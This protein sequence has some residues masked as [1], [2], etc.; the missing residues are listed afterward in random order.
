VCNLKD[1][2]IN[3]TFELA[4]IHGFRKFTIDDIAKHLGISKK[5]IY[6]NFETKEEI[7]DGVLSRVLNKVKEKTLSAIDC[8]T[9]WHGKM[10]A[11]ILCH[12]ID[13]IPIETL[14][15]IKNIF[16][17]KGHKIEDFKLF[18]QSL[19]SSMLEEGKCKN[20]IRSNV[21]IEVVLIILERTIP[22]ITNYEFLSN[23]NYRLNESIDSLI[24]IIFDGINAP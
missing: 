8:E 19:I 5:T 6:K 23:H 13:K 4:K 18:K 12:H 9:T 1:R 16:P 22:S 15:E 14:N 7:I 10:R 20:F 2:I 24:N 21:S 17:N 3:A 11:A